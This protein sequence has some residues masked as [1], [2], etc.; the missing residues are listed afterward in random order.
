[1]IGKERRTGSC[2]ETDFVSWDQVKALF[3]VGD[4]ISCIVTDHCPFGVL[5]SLEQV[6]AA[7]VIERIRMHRDGF[8]TPDDYPPVG[9][10]IK[11]I[12]LGFR[13]Y[14]QQVELAMPKNETASDRQRSIKEIC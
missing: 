14:S 9:S 2:M 1:M 7:G 4:T 13:D 6:P 10:V 3:A 12:V 11:A 8:Q 5:V